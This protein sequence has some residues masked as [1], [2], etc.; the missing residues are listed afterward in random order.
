MLTT[1]DGDYSIGSQ[2]AQGVARVEKILQKGAAYDA[3]KLMRGIRRPAVV[4]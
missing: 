2:K 1:W 3:A 4:V